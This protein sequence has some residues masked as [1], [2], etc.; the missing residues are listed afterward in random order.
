MFEKSFITDCEGPLTLND[1][2]FELAVHFIEEGCELFKILSLYDDYLVD[3]VK[4]DN[5]KA[6]NM[7]TVSNVFLIHYSYA[8]ESRF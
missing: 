5:Y 4:K 7:A 3:I 1:N 8:S 2:A 6:G